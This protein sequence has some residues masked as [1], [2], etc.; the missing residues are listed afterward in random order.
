MLVIFGQAPN[1]TG[2]TINVIAQSVVTSGALT[3]QNQIESNY[4]SEFNQGSSKLRYLDFNAS[5]DN[6]LFSKSSTVQP[7][8]TQ[9][10]II[11]KI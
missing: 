2:R 8:A 5:W 1:I 10:L 11:I 9:I 7:N 4:G 3:N 6:S